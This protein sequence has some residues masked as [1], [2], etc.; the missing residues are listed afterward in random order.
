MLRCRQY[1]SFCEKTTLAIGDQSI[2]NVRHGIPFGWDG[3]AVSAVL[4][5]DAVNFVFGQGLTDNVYAMD[6][7]PK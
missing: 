4:R 2:E 6:S 7:Q 3:N 1:E 5:L